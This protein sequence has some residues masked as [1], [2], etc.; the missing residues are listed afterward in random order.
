VHTEDGPD[1]AGHTDGQGVFGSD[2]RLSTKTQ[3]TADY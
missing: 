3:G 1:C 2:K